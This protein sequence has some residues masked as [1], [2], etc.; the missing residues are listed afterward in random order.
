MMLG[1]DGHGL[2]ET[3]WCAIAV[4]PD[5][6]LEVRGRLGATTYAGEQPAHAERMAA[7]PDHQHPVGA[8][9]RAGEGRTGLG[10][11]VLFHWLDDMEQRLLVGNAR[12]LDRW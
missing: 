8:P 10:A 12:A 3:R 11:P 4:L 6:W 1:S 9:V 5:A 2:P 7:R